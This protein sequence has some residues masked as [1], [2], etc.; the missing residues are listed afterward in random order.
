MDLQKFLKVNQIEFTLH[1]HP[2]VFSSEEVIKNFVNIPG[3][4]CKNL[5]LCDKKEQQYFLLIIPLHKKADLKKFAKL[6]NV[7]KV[8][9]A[10]HIL[11]KEKLGLNP[12]SVS[13]TGILHDKNAEVDIY[14]DQELYD[15]ERVNFHPDI[16]TASLELSREMFHKF[17]QTTKRQYN[18]IDL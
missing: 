14:I 2:A 7:S 11:L 12:G 6:V 1:Q 8:T 13:P 18:V 4:V 9:F 15:S 16:N 10:N 3:V 17:L 5:F